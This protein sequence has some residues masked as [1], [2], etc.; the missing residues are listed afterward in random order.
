MITEG[1]FCLF[2]LKNIHC[3][4]SLESPR[5]GDSN[6]FPQHMFLWTT[7]ENYPSIIKIILQLSSK[8]LIPSLSVLLVMDTFISLV[9]LLCRFAKI[10]EPL[11]KRRDQLEKVK[12]I[13]QFVRDVED[14]KLWIQERM[15]IATSPNFGNSLLSVQ[16]LEKKNHVSSRF[17]PFRL[18]LSLWDIKY[19]IKRDSV[20]KVPCISLGFWFYY[21]WLANLIDWLQYG[22]WEIRY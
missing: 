4:Y 18:F 1:W 5:R 2:L 11:L 16:L 19:H 8:L 21:I 3:G 20:I 13:H 14:E 17:Q 7:D 9:F 10:Q 12:Y 6:E 22:D 15:P